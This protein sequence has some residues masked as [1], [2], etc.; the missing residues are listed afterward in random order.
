M[1]NERPVGPE[2]DPIRV[3]IDIAENQS[4]SEA[5]KE[6]FMSTAK[7]RLR[8]QAAHGLLGLA[9]DHGFLGFVVRRSLS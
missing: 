6:Q 8:K 3:M 2:E 1:P 4:I 9:Y 7:N 5:D